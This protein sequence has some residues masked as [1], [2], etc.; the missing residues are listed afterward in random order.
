MAAHVPRRLA[1]FLWHGQQSQGIVFDNA[2]VALV[3]EKTGQRGN[4]NPHIT[5]ENVR[6]LPPCRPNIVVA[7]GRNYV[8]HAAQMGVEVPSEPLIF[9]KPNTSVIA[10]GEAIVY[11]AWLSAKV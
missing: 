6:L 5:F 11:P 1:S 8:D 7:V 10:S 3:D 4:T 9:L 2:I